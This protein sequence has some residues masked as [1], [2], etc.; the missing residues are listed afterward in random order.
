MTTLTEKIAALRAEHAGTG[1]F[2]TEALLDVLE[3]IAGRLDSPETEEDASFDRAFQHWANSVGLPSEAV[4]RVSE[5][6]DAGRR[7]WVVVTEWPEG[8][9]WSGWLLS[10]ED[11]EPRFKRLDDGD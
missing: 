4:W 6:D 10:V 8:N 2:K 5:Q 11:D 1:G 9:D 3:E 7:W